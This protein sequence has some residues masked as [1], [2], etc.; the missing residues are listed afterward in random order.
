[1]RRGFALGL[2][3]QVIHPRRALRLADGCVQRQRD[4][5]VLD[6]RRVIALVQPLI[7]TLSITSSASA[8]T[9]AQR[10]QQKRGKTWHVRQ[11]TGPRCR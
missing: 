8:G 3:E 4:L 7:W 5:D 6:H 11:H 2:A 10:Q 1:V 9:E